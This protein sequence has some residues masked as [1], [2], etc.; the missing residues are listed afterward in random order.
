MTLKPLIF[1]GSVQAWKDFCER[2]ELAPVDVPLVVEIAKLY[3]KK[4]RT[5]IYGGGFDWVAKDKI[6][7]GYCRTHDIDMMSDLEFSKL[8]ITN[9]IDFS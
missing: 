3:G 2:Y 1:T 4:D 9:S 5:L 8:Y 7:A 6:I